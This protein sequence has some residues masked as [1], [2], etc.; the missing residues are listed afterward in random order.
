M[1]N[2]PVDTARLTT[3]VGGAIEAATTPD[4]TPRRNRA[5]QVLFNVP[6]VVVIENASAD[7][8]V[9]RI[10]GPVPQVPPLTPVRLVEL[11]ARPWTMDGRSGV[12]F[13]AE[14]LQPATQRS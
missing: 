7:T 2:I 4:G 5:G 1:R 11:V 10:P 8:L 12:S 14:G 9:V 13:T 6:L 3:L